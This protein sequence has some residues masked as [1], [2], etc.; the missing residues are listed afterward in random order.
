MCFLRLDSVA[1]HL[2]VG[3]EALAGLERRFSGPVACDLTLSAAAQNALSAG[4]QP[5]AFAAIVAFRARM[6]ACRASRRTAQGTGSLAEGRVEAAEVLVE[7][8]KQVPGSLLLWEARLALDEAHATSEDDVNTVL[9]LYERAVDA[10]ESA[11]G[12]STEARHRLSV[13]MLAFAN[14]RA[15]PEALKAAE[16]R[17]AA[18]FGVA[19]PLVGA[20]ASVPAGTQAEAGKK[21]S[22]AECLASS[23]EDAP[24]DTAAR[25]MADSRVASGKTADAAAPSQQQAPPLA[26]ANPIVAAAQAQ[27]AAMGFGRGGAVPAPPSAPP[28]APPGAAGVAAATAA[29]T[30]QYEMYTA[31]QQQQWY[32]WYAWQ[33][34]A[35]AQQGWSM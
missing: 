15:T 33:Q 18:R 5:D 20:S 26:A 11:N 21:R 12:L 13:R 14:Q 34:A 2:L 8:L 7:A 4:D 29:A 28:S 24:H 35:Q 16:D 19:G 6:L 27:A 3:I 32:Q 25:S 1:P 9:A 31:E 10:P 22:L 30:S 17:H 23:A